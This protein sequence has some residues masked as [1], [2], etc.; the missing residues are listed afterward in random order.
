MVSATEQRALPIRVGL[1][2]VLVNVPWQETTGERDK[3]KAKEEVRRLALDWKARY[4]YVHESLDGRR[5]VGRIPGNAKRAVASAPALAP[6]L[7]FVCTK[8][9]LIIHAMP[10]DE[11]YVLELLG[12]GEF[13]RL[14]DR[15]LIERDATKLIDQ[16]LNEADRQRQAHGDAFELLISGDPPSASYMMKRVAESTRAVALSELLAGKT[17]P[18]TALPRQ[19]QGLTPPQQIWILCA[20]AGVIAAGIAWG[21]AANEATKRKQAADLQA[22]QAQAQFEAQLPSL[23][24]A[25][26]YA[27]VKRSLE[28]TTTVPAPGAL[29]RRCVAAAER[30]GNNQAGWMVASVE[31]DSLRPTVTVAFRRGQDSVGTNVS[32]T[33]WTETVFG[34][35]PTLD[36]SGMNAA[37]SVDAPLPEPRAAVLLRDLP[38]NDRILLELVTRLQAVAIAVENLAHNVT[39]ASLVTLSYIDPDKERQPSPTGEVTSPVPAEQGYMAGMWSLSGSDNLVPTSMNLDW[40]WLTLQKMTI[41]LDSNGATTWRLEGTYYAH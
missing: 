28:E 20:I 5:A 34:R 11:F 7:A 35:R 21:Y 22:A 39:P 41:N 14:S 1:H 4:V 18:A 2:T 16:L 26:I 38:S 24:A 10:N 8:R 33:S 15:V 19:V 9:T 13:N 17:P 29:I 36:V 31:C 27:A 25:R 30:V 6:W 3:N 37:L 32:L 12:A 40:P 23:R